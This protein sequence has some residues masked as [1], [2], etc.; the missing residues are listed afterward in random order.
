MAEV[1][2]AGSQLQPDSIK[3]FL[4]PDEITLKRRL[5]HKET[6]KSHHSHKKLPP[7]HFTLL[8]SY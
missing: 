8:F 3:C 7:N 1:Y 2:F 4:F 6:F 5:K